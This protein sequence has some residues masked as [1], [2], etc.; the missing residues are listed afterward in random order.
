MSSLRFTMSDDSKSNFD[1]L[2]WVI[3]I[4]RT[5]EEELEDD[6][7]LPVSIFNVP[8]LLMVSDPDSYVPQQVAI[9]PYHYWRPELYEMERYKLAAAKRFQKQ[10]QSF[11]LENLVQQ[12]TKL[13]QRIRACYHKFLDFNGE[14]L[15]WMMAVD[16]SFL[17]EF[18]QVYAIQEGSKVPGVSSR[19]MSHLVDYAGKKSAHNA[20]LRD[21]V[22]LEN[23]LPLFVLREMLE[24][25]FTS[26]EVADDLLFSMA[27][28]LFKELSPFKLMEDYPNVQ[29]SGCAHLL[30]FFYDM[31]VP[32]L[33]QQSDIVEVDE[34]QLE[35]EQ[36]RENQPQIQIQIFISNLPGLRIL[37]VPVESFFFSLL[38]KEQENPEN[39]DSSS[40]SLNNKPP[41]VEEI[42]IPS[43]SEL[44]DA[45]VGFLPTNKGISS[46]NFD[47]KT[48]TFH[49]PTI[50]LDVN[51]EVV[52]RN[53]V[54][55]EASA[56]SGPLVL[57]R[58]TELMNGI[59]DSEEDVKILRAQGIVLNHLKSDEE[60]A[61][62]WNGMNS[63]IRLTK[64]A[65][66]DKAIE[67]VNKYYNGRLKVKAWKLMKLYV[68][69]SWQCF[70]FLAAILLLLL[71]TLQA[72]CSVYT[73]S[74]IFQVD[75]TDE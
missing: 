69:S 66:L 33:K 19:S 16:A 46:I 43:V 5:L 36:E 56:A 7:E 1:E 32:K 38:D 44:L 64:V 74:R 21:I 65:F 63:S 14:T 42:A 10:L 48:R 17:L 41:L 15:V 37:K 22:M 71:M 12:L 8:R 61:N 54:A 2:R 58:Y 45:A 31:I 62:M 13:E 23:Q 53:L 60:A 35:E 67:D 47:A 25:K 20:I 55:Y 68:F 11:K 40:N 27:V 3:Q 50:S 49:L 24:F 30:D 29:V 72:F 73:C 26:L 75:N 9:G 4:R 18:L 6:G 57:T 70:T 52:L 39:G 34:V 28:G 59:T 51:T